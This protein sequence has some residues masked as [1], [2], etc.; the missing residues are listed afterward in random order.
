MNFEE[1]EIPMMKYHKEYQRTPPNN[2]DIEN[3]SQ[4]D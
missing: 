3:P 2:M 1:T 4:D